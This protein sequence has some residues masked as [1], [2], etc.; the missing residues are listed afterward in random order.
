MMGYE[1]LGFVGGM[2]VPSVQ[3]YGNGFIEGANAA[4]SEK[5]I[6]KKVEVRCDY[7]GTF[8]PNAQIEAFCGEWYKQGTQVIFSC[9]GG[10]YSS[11]AA[12]AC[13]YDGKM[14]G[15]DV[16]QAAVIDS[17]GAGMTITSAMKGLGPSVEDALRSIIIDD[18]WILKAGT[19]ANL[20]LVSETDMSLNY[21]QLS[22]STQWSDN[23]SKEDY[24]VLVADIMN[25]K[26]E[27]R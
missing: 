5:G 4:A 15:V 23:F 13:K 26:Y 27:C 11:V 7:A 12:A 16:D 24:Q 1:K 14:I 17:Y 19:I 22:D 20:G 8:S 25:G 21:V 9:G 2:E 10:I 18:S 3:R 6:E